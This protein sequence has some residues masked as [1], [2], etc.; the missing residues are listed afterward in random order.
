MLEYQ[1]VQQILKGVKMK[2]AER[3]VEVHEIEP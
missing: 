1:V 2:V 3:F